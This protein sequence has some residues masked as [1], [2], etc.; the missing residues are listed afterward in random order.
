MV[1]QHTALP[2]SNTS[3]LRHLSGIPSHRGHGRQK[4]GVHRADRA[5]RVF[6][7]L[8]SHSNATREAARELIPARRPDQVARR[9]RATCSLRRQLGVHGVPTRDASSG[10]TPKTPQDAGNPSQL[11]P[12]QIMIGPA[13]HHPA[14]SAKQ[15]LGY[16]CTT[17]FLPPWTLP[18][19]LARTHTQTQ[20]SLID[21]WHRPLWRISLPSELLSPLPDPLTPDCI[22]ISYASWQGDT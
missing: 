13:A 8:T 5:G 18:A 19:K 14:S 11:R 3:F 20:L 10:R 9:F 15:H 17:W 6:V 4:P 2:S 21:S 22:I 7:H 16:G 12:L 1:A